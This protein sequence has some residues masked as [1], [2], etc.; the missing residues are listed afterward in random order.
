MSSIISSKYYDVNLVGN[1]VVNY[2]VQKLCCQFSRQKITII[3]S[4]YCL[5]FSCLLCRQL[6]RP[7]IMLSIISS[8][9]HVVNYL[10][11]ILCLQFNR[12]L[13]CPN[14]MLSIYSSIMFS[15]ISSKYYVINLFIN[16]VVNYLVISSCPSRGS[17]CLVLIFL[18][19]IA[20][21]SIPGLQYWFYVACSVVPDL[22]F[23]ASGT[24][25]N[26]HALWCQFYQSRLVVLQVL[27]CLLNGASSIF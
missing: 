24:D 8:K 17:V 16:Y 22:S 2:L 15:I 7:N 4:K 1:Y 13:S 12:R 25:S 5:Q 20:G 21:S 9:Y 3:S 14:I 26:L 18:F 11:Q 19:W 6:S 10:V 27:S 23:Q